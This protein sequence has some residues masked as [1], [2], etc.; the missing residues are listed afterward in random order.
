MWDGA[1]GAVVW[2][3]HDDQHGNWLEAKIAAGFQGGE[4]GAL[5]VFVSDLVSIPPIFLARKSWR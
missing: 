1:R 4:A 3:H 2:Q 5:I